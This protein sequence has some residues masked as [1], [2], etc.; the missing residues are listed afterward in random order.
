MPKNIKVGVGMMERTRL[1]YDFE[2]ED[3]KKEV[4]AL[5]EHWAAKWRTFDEQR[6]LVA[7]CFRA[8]LSSS[9]IGDPLDPKELLIASNSHDEDAMEHIAAKWLLEYFHVQNLRE[10]ISIEEGSTDLEYLIERAVMLGQLQERFYWR[11]GVEEKTGKRPEIMALAGRKQVMGGKQGN[12]MRTDTSFEK[13]HGKEAQQYV[14]ALHKK[15][16]SLS[17]ADMQRL[18]SEKYGVSAITIKRALTNPKKVGSSRS[19]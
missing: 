5:I 15:N 3:A 14:D 2:R 8:L 18:T 19:E 11:Q 9:G 13:T 16:P 4:E 12:D 10:D 17:W 7:E 6:E 1:Q